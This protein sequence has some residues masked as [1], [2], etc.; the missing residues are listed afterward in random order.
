[1]SFLKQL[2]ISTVT[3]GYIVE[4]RDRSFRESELGGPMSFSDRYDEDRVFQYDA[5]LL[6]YIKDKLNLDPDDTQ[7]AE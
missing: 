5:E 3:N 1:M 7:E 6:A 2:T 4:Y